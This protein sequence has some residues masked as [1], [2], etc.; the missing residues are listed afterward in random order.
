MTIPQPELMWLQQEISM[1]KIIVSLQDS[2]ILDD[3]EIFDV[4]N[5]FTNIKNY[6]KIKNSFNKFFY[7]QKKK[8]KKRKK[9]EKKRKKC[10][11]LILEK[12]KNHL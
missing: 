1:I 3:W 4:R 12:I 8:K 7:S 9:K 5:F 10:S 6:K 11:I 2:S